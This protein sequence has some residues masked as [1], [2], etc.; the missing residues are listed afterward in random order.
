MAKKILIVEDHND[1]RWLLADIL[2]LGY[3]TIEAE[4]AEQAL[5]KATSE[6]P[7][8]ILMDIALPEMNGI[9]AA[10]ALKENPVTAD[11]PII[12]LSASDQKLWK[13]VA[14]Q[15]GMVEY[16][17]KPFFPNVLKDAI[18]RVLRLISQETD[19]R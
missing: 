8:L 9:D 1:L 19:H 18:E 11:I 17:Q 3:E 7:D 10:R 14:L 5:E 13:K 16:I 4:T 6:H 15:A 12:A 2:C